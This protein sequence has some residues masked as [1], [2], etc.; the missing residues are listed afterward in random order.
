[1]GASQNYPLLSCSDN[2]PHIDGSPVGTAE[3]S[4]CHYGLP[5]RLALLPT[6]SRDNA[7]TVGY[8][9]EQVILKGT[10]TSPMLHDLSTHDGRHMAGHDDWA[11]LIVEESILPRP[12]I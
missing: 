12:G 8:R 2:L 5:V 9:T 3:S 7:V 10:C 1:M 6:P 11:V 4:S